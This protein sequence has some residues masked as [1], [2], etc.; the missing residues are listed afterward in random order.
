MADT[1]VVVVAVPRVTF[2]QTGVIVF[3]GFTIGTLYYLM[4]SASI[5]TH[6]N[7]SFVANI[8]TDI[9]AFIVAIGMVYLGA[10]LGLDTAPSPISYQMLL[11]IF[12]TAI[13]TEH[14]WQVAFNKI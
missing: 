6:V 3:G 11:I 13:F 8:W 4:M 14:V 1:E 7:C 10:V 2:F 12:G 5:P 9:F